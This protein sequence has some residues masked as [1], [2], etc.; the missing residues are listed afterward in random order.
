MSVLKVNVANP[1]A[2]DDQKQKDTTVSGQLA[3]I[4]SHQGAGHLENIHTHL[5]HYGA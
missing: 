3:T 2:S 5:T 4:C 1:V